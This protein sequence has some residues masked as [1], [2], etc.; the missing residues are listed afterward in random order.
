ME[1]K[2]LRQLAT[3]IGATN[4]K[5][6]GVDLKDFQWHKTVEID[7]SRFS[8]YK[9]TQ[10][11]NLIEDHKAERGALTAARDIMTWI[12]AMKKDS[13]GAKSRTVQQF[14]ALLIA[15]LQKTPGHRIFK[16]D[17]VSDVWLCYYVGE[18]SYTPERRD[19]GYSI[20]AH[21]DI[22][23]YYYEFGIMTH[24]DAVFRAEV[25]GQPVEAALA[26]QGFVVETTELREQY[27]ADKELFSAEVGQIGKQYLARGQ[28]TD[29]LDGNRDK[30]ED[31]WYWRTTNTLMLDRND[32]PAHVVC[33]VFREEDKEEKEH[34]VRFDPFWWGKKVRAKLDDDDDDADEEVIA[35]ENAEIRDAT[36]L[37]KKTTED[38]A[39]AEGPYVPLHPIMACFD[40]KR[41]LRLRIHV[42]Q[43]TPY[44]YDPKLGDKLV[45][46]PD[47]RELVDILLAQS[48]SGVFKD[49]IAGKG[50]GAVIACTGSPGLGK[51]LTAEIYA[52]VSQRPLYSI[53]CSQLGTEPD[54]LEDN[55]LKTFARSARW[56]AILLLDEADVYVRRRGDD[57]EQNAIV[58][59]FL[60]TL[61]YYKGVMF[62][63]TNRADLIDDAVLSRCVARIEYGVPNAEEQSR[64]WRI[65]S[66]TAGI[67]LPDAEIKKV[68]K[69][70]PTLSGRDVKNLLK[71]AGLVSLAKG[72]PVT[73]EMI[74]FVK[75]FKPTLDEVHAEQRH[76]P[77]GEQ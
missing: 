20:P 59:V 57:L 43:L 42:R 72:K 66:D 67:K 32:E 74:S 26:A 7:L 18:V 73:A 25:I 44:V 28:A 30:S 31:R 3:A 55:L 58:G 35:Q 61:E 22:E 24:E 63:T 16:K 50:G 5:P 48:Q 56:N 12:T 1:I 77:R 33:D 2:L 11:K 46:P 69:A 75:R 4:L 70:H 38:E 45:M 39:A 9:L 47:N 10:L 40:L 52:E 60:R 37:D 36:A 68:V 49:I 15:H 76:L 27:L 54:D 51:T 21:A 53:Q 13:A 71:L 29:D 8:I 19:R 41:H 64:I 62:M 17:A 34:K 6:Y 23:L 65:L 14:S